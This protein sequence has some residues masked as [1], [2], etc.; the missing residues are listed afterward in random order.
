MKKYTVVILGMILALGL[1]LQSC[2]KENIEPTTNIVVNT[3]KED[4]R[5]YG[6]VRGNIGFNFEAGFII[7]V[8]KNNIQIIKRDCIKGTDF[9]DIKFCSDNSLK[10]YVIG[11]RL[12]IDNDPHVGDVT[13]YY[14]TAYAIYNGTKY[15]GNEINIAS[16]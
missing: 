4:G 12:P 11:F 5:L 16:K 8:I 6:E 13:A 7:R 3:S 14:V 9:T 2:S 15:T 1:M 10:W